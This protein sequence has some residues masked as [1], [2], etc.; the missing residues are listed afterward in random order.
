MADDPVAKFFEEY[1]KQLLDALQK[2]HEQYDKAILT[3]SS[4]GLALSITLLKDLFPVDKV[5][6]PEVLVWSWYLF[7]AAIISTIFSF[8]TSI[9]S[10]N[11]QRDYFHKYYIEKKSDYKDKTNWWT[12]ITKWLNRTSA[13]CFIVGVVTTIIFASG[14]F[15]D[16]L[17]HP[18]AKE[19]EPTVA[20]QKSMSS[21]TNPVHHKKRKKP[22]S[23]LTNYRI[24]INGSG[25]VM[26]ELPPKVAPQTVVPNAMPENAKQVYQK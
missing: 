9:R 23:A 16:K 18:P 4:G 3:L 6:M 2:S 11:T 26:M 22:S 24:T 25:N 8:M 14:N 1:E 5:V 17:K 10:T 20:V 12:V 7:G 15:R 13:V 21:A 19:K